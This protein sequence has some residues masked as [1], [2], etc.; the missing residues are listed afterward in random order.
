MKEARKEKK[1]YDE[2][3]EKEGRLERELKEA[4]IIG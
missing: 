2:S 1:K 3:K 4:K